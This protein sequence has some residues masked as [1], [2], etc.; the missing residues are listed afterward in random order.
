MSDCSQLTSV[1][2]SSLHTGRICPL[3]IVMHTKNSKE[4]QLQYCDTLQLQYF[5]PKIMIQQ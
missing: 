4:L 2:K 3:F 1:S 5:H